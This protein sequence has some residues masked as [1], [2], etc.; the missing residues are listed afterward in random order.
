MG[1]IMDKFT[2]TYDIEK[3][4]RSNFGIKQS[5]LLGAAALGF[6]LQDIYAAVSTMTSK[7]FY[8]SMT[9]IRNHKLWQDVYHVPYGG[10]ML[11]VKFT[12]GTITAFDLLSFKEK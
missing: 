6:E 3:F 7:H 8:K 9:S 2:P 1:R 5:A 10:Y 11:Y 4:K 12:R